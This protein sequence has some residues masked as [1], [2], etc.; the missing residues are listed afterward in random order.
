VSFKTFSF[1]WWKQKKIFW[2][3][4]RILVS[5]DFHCT[6]ILVTCFGQCEPK[7]WLPNFLEISY[8]VFH[9]RKKVL[10]SYG[11][12]T[13]WGWVNDDRTVIFGWTIPLTLKQFWQIIVLIRVSAGVDWWHM[14]DSSK[15]EEMDWE[16]CWHTHTHTHTPVW[17]GWLSVPTCWLKSQTHTEWVVV[18]L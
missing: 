9:R 13:T 2:I 1:S 15:K 11:F 6:R 7:L 3:I 5:V 10:Q 18:C 8:F 4:I 16:N 17:S 14:V 12:G